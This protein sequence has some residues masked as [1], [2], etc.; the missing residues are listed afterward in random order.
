MKKVFTLIELL[1][2][3]A[4]K[5]RVL[6]LFQ[7][8]KIDKNCTSLRP[9]G[10]TSRLPQAN[11]SHLHIFTQSAFTLIELLVVIAIIAILAGMLLPALNSA[12]NK[13]MTTTCVNNLKQRGTAMLMYAGDFN[14]H[15]P[16]SYY[17]V[18]G[19]LYPLK[20][21]PGQH[22]VFQLD[23]LGERTWLPANSISVCPTAATRGASAFATASGNQT[24]FVTNY[25][26]TAGEHGLSYPNTYAAIQE[27]SEVSRKVQKIKGNVIS[28]E[29]EYTSSS[30]WL[31]GYEGTQ[32][33]SFTVRV[34]QKNV[35]RMPYSYSWATSSTADTQI[36]SR[37]GYNHSGSGNWLFKDGHV[38]T[39]RYRHGLIDSKFTISQ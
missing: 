24:A 13:A 39:I 19:F 2:N 14:D 29:H 15:L 10:R 34:I 26:M 23:K 38:A 20:Y 30:T 32:K 31:D 25:S 7:L 1:V 12:R 11:S 22:W 6:P 28:G 33:K 21:L 17:S 36:Y 18:D 3:A 8:K 16:P 9:T 4:C 35:F 27:S 37:A 5:V